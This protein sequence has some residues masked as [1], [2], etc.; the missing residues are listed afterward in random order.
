MQGF[1]T[2][3]AGERFAYNTMVYSEPEI[4]RIATNAFDAAMKRGKRLCSVDKANV[5]EVSQLWREVRV[6]R[7]QCSLPAMLMHTLCFGDVISHRD[8][9]IDKACG[10]L[11]HARS[12]AR[13]SFCI[14]PGHQ[15]CDTFVAAGHWLCCWH[16]GWG[17]EGGVKCVHLIET[18]IAG[19]GGVAIVVDCTD[20]HSG[21]VR[22]ALPG[23]K[24]DCRDEW[25]DRHLP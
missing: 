22:C 15:C 2:N 24:H 23:C 20:V 12:F 21:H 1:D 13:V 25:I 19:G 3:E 7:R 5:L 11:T 18:D 6:T 17:G 4:E 14:V 8:E 9:P 16:G 10:W